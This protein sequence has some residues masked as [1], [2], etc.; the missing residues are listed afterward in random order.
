MKIATAVAD[1]LNWDTS[2][3]GKEHTAKAIQ[4]ADA[5]DAVDDG[6]EQ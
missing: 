6:R 4:H 3:W 1:W 5:L 2:L